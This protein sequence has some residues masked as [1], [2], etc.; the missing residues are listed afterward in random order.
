VANIK[1]TRGKAKN[2]KIE[3]A[4]EV[5][6]TSG[7]PLLLLMGIGMQMLM[8]PD[9]FCKDLVSRGFQVAR[10]DNRDVG[11]ST[12]LTE[13]GEPKLFDMIWRPKKAMRYSL[14]HM[15]KDTVAV[16][17]ALGWKSANIVGGSLGGMIAQQVAITYP[18][19]VRSLTSI[20][21]SPSFKIGRAKTMFSIKVGSLLAQ[22]LHNETE[23]ANQ[24]VAVFKLL[25]TPTTNYPMD[26]AW[27]RE[28]GAE[29]FRRS[30]DPAGKLRQQ[31]TMI[32]APD[33]TKAL[34]QLKIPTLVMHGEIDPMIRLKGGIATA[35]AIP[36]AKLVILKGVGHGAFPREVWPE[37]IENICKIADQK[38]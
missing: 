24:Q 8:W 26:K 33:R 28:V 16:L 36:N 37:M 22:P 2:G 4:Y 25:G 1:I 18:K 35:K 9:D 11:L 27:L 13:L 38:D 12:H 17:D 31:A 21:A 15:A 7:E 20:M 10:M 19:R 30:Y 5:F 29:S 14:E 34:E 32:A 3:L 23:A 6:G